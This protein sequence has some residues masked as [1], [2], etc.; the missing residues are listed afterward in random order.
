M[1]QKNKIIDHTISWQGN[2]EEDL[3]KTTDGAIYGASKGIIR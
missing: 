1:S 2:K 3:S